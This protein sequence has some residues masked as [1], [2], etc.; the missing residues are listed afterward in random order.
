MV[1]LLA[2]GPSRKTQT[3][4]E[5]GVEISRRRRLTASARPCLRAQQRLLRCRRI[6]DDIGFHRQ[7]RPLYPQAVDRMLL[8]TAS[9]LQPREELAE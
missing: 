3:R 7:L 1:V 6:A 9:A 2:T 8:Q 4:T 5:I